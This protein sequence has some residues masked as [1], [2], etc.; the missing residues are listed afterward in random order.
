MHILNIITH[1]QIALQKLCNLY[2]HKRSQD[3]YLLVPLPIVDTI[4][5]LNLY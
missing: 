4:M 3:I 1:C 5:P 2:F